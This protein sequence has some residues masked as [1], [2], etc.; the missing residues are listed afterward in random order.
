MDDVGEPR[1]A[2]GC[3]EGDPLPLG[4]LVVA[5]GEAGRIMARA[6]WPDWAYLVNG[7]WWGRA[8]IEA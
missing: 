8:D 1:D 4:L 3:A 5:G 6:E 2:G 7:K